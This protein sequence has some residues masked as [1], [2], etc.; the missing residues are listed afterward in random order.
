MQKQHNKTMEWCQKRDRNVST[1][2]GF[3]TLYCDFF[4]LDTVQ[5]TVSASALVLNEDSNRCGQSALA[6]IPTAIFICHRS[7]IFCLDEHGQRIK[8]PPLKPP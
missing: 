1:K 2:R 3:T 6:Q 4:A 8:Q 5:N 7:T